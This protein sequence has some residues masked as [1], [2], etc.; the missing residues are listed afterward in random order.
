[1]NLHDPSNR[2]GKPVPFAENLDDFTLD[3]AK[4]ASR[5]CERCKG[6]GLAPI[7]NPRYSGDTIEIEIDP[8]HGK[9][10][11]LMRANAFCVCP[12][13][14]KVAILNQQTSKDVFLRTPDLH[15]VIAG[16]YHNWVADDPTYD[17]N[18]TFDI[19]SLPEAVKRLAKAMRVPRI[20]DEPEEPTDHDRINRMFDDA[21]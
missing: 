2:L 18:Q 15:D 21:V 9:R 13:G 8:W 3:G 11:V 10:Q 1:M 14:R 16:K 19:E 12:A 20:Y 5:N 6:E 4:A 7:F 17:P